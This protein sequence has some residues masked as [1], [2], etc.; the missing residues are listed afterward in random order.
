M[1]TTFGTY[2]GDEVCG[3][4]GAMCRSCGMGCGEDMAVMRCT[5]PDANQFF[6]ANYTTCQ[7]LPLSFWEDAWLN[8]KFIFILACTGVFF[9]LFALVY[10]PGRALGKRLKL[11][12]EAKKR[13][14]SESMRSP[15]L[16]GGE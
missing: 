2:H 15:L 12:R 6:D 5:C 16:G 14:R 7:S 9:S 11:K 4:T 8:H 3:T 13:E 10:Y 1:G